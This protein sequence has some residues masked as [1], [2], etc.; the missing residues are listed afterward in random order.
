MI[1]MQNGHFIFTNNSSSSDHTLFLPEINEMTNNTTKT[2][3]STLAIDAAPAAIPP[4]PKIAAIIAKITR[5]TVQRN[6]VCSFKFIENVWPYLSDLV[7]LR[8]RKKLDRISAIA[9]YLDA[10]RLYYH[11]AIKTIRFRLL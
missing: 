2:K 4:N 9:R 10:I 5:I 3:K 7:T 8:S 6:I 1:H 11:E